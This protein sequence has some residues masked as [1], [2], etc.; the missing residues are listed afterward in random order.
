M[1]RQRRRDGRLPR[2]GGCPLRPRLVL[3]HNASADFEIQEDGS[4]P[5]PIGCRAIRSASRY[6]QFR[7][8]F[9]YF[10]FILDDRLTIGAPILTGSAKL[11]TSLRRPQ[12]IQFGNNLARLPGAIDCS[13]FRGAGGAS[14]PQPACFSPVINRRGPRRRP[15]LCRTDAMRSHAL[16]RPFLGARGA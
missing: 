9:T 8:D 1:G 12:I 11:K 5:L 16:A 3:C 13:I 14:L 7:L 10:G 2:G 4:D 15:R 6:I